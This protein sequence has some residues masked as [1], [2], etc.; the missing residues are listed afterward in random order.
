MGNLVGGQILAELVASQGSSQCRFAAKE[1]K[2]AES[3]VFRRKLTGQKL[4]A[5]ERKFA[6]SAVRRRKLTERKLAAERAEIRGERAEIRGTWFHS[7]TWLSEGR[8]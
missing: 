3:A 2:F 1:R 8:N 5:K 4:A 6:E 7:R